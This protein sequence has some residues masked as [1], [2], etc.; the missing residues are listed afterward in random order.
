MGE[1]VTKPGVIY[2]ATAAFAL[3]NLPLVA[4]AWFVFLMGGQSA[5]EWWLRASL[6]VAVA[7][8]EIA[9]V[10]WTIGPPLVDWI[11]EKEFVR[12]GEKPSWERERK[13]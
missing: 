4:T 7:G 3:L 5:S 13:P 8:S 11:D 6:A 2:R 12:D 9:I 1:W 10:T